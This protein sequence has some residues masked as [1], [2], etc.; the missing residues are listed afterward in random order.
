MASYVYGNTV[1]KE[2]QVAPKH[3]EKQPKELSQH[4]QRNRSK[5]LHMNRGYVMFLAV[6]A[7]V[8]LFACVQYLRLQSEVS[9]HSAYITSLQRELETKKETNT[10]KYNSIVNSMNLEEIREKA[11]NELGMVY[12]ATEQVIEY[13]NPTGNAVT[14]YSSIPESGIIASSNVKK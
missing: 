9:E 3:V 11:M 14:Q 6:A 10:T 7:L 12:A 13:Q 2:I 5:A 8:A 1:R 4:V